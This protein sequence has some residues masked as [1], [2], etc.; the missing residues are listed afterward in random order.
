MLEQQPQELRQ[1]RNKA[2]DRNLK[3]ICVIFSFLFA[4][5]ISSILLQKKIKIT[6]TDNDDD[7]DFEW[8]GKILVSEEKKQKQKKTKL[9]DEVKKSK[10]K[11]EYSV[12][13]TLQLEPDLE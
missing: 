8:R 6:N 11:V 1:G 4:F 5:L 7:D 3:E 9:I 10:R 13:G 12:F 2:V